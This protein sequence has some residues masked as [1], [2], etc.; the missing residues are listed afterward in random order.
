[1]QHDVVEI[2][3][4][5]VLSP[6]QKGQRASQAYFIEDIRKIAIMILS[7]K[8]STSTPQN[9]LSGDSEGIQI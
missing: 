5:L 3:P 9:P 1:M 4:L 7:I 2:L 6:Q 8:K